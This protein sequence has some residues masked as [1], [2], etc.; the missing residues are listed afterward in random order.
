LSC[1]RHFPSHIKDKE[2]FLDHGL[3][4]L[5]DDQYPE[6]MVYGDHQGNKSF[7]SYA[8]GPGYAIPIDTQGHNMLTNQKDGSFKASEVEVWGVEFKEL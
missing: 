1:S 7:A 4:F 8:Q 3:F 2:I 6:L 5:A